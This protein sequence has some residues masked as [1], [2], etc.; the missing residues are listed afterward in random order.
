MCESGLVKTVSSNCL[1]LICAKFRSSVDGVYESFFF[2]KDRNPD[3]YEK[4]PSILMLATNVKTKP[5]QPEEQESA[6][7]TWGWLLRVVSNRGANILPSQRGK[8]T[9]EA[10]ELF[11]EAQGLEPCWRSQSKIL[12]QVEFKHL[13]LYQ[14]KSSGGQLLPPESQLLWALFCN[15]W[16]ESLL[17]RAEGGS[18]S[19]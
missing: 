18:W 4:S 5:N 2:N 3:F 10:T 8:G 19:F 9:L 13:F 17:Q 16:P 15:H 1:L 6:H 7:R 14:S 11:V 12:L